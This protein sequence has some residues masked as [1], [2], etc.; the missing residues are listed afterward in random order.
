MK[1]YY[2][3]VMALIYSE[4]ADQF[5]DNTWRVNFKSSYKI[6]FVFV[7]LFFVVVF[8]ENGKYFEKGKYSRIMSKGWFL[9]CDA[10]HTVT[11]C[12]YNVQIIFSLPLPNWKHAG[13][14]LCEKNVYEQLSKLLHPI[15][16]FVKFTI[17]L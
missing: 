14:I 11:V 5:I 4:P 13:I 10:I 8:F 2:G 9:K 7:F 3:Y 12:I 17:N 15:T 16:D 1:N 6:I